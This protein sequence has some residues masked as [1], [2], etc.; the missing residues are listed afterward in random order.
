MPRPVLQSLILADH[1]YED[2]LTGK[3][4]IAGVFNRII[5]GV[6]VIKQMGPPMQPQAPAPQYIPPPVQNLAPPT[7]LSPE[8]FSAPPQF[9]SPNMPASAPP[10]VPPAPPPAISPATPAPSHESPPPAADVQPPAQPMAP[11]PYRHPE[12]PA[13]EQPPAAQPAHP[14]PAHTAAHQPPQPLN[15]NNLQPGQRV[16]E[17]PPT[18]LQSGSP[19][20]YLSLTEVRGAMAFILQL[21]NLEDDSQLFRSD[22]RVECHNPL[23]TVEMTV[24]LPPISPPQ[25]GIYALELM[26]NNEILGSL[27]I[28]VE[29]A[30][31]Q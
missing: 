15:P 29:D 24:P 3:R 4:I 7:P 14:V 31:Q 6:R 17:I 21:V 22:L 10:P 9:A 20:A 1:V 8:D 13:P 12:V 23:L 25:A 16:L 2:K 18:G 11:T 28:I 26:W 19:F 27:R 5:R 30:A